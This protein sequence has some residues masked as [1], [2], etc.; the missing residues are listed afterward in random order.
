MGATKI[1]EPAGIIF[2]SASFAA[3]GAFSSGV[4]VVGCEACPSG[5]A[6]VDDCD[7]C[8]VAI[9]DASDT[10]PIKR[11][12]LHNIGTSEAAHLPPMAGK[13]NLFRRFRAPANR[14]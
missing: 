14:C 12:A 6:C 13:V 8:A 3:G 1:L 11:T 5:A 4:V 10:A 9:A 7:C 2:D